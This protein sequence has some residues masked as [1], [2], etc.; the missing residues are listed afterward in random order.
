MFSEQDQLWLAGRYPGLK[1]TADKV[2]GTIDLKAAFQLDT[3]KFQIIYPGDSNVVGGCELTGSFKVTM[4][5]RSSGTMLRVPALTIDGY[6]S[7]KDRHIDHDGIACLCSPFVEGEYMSPDLDGRRFME[8]LVVPFLYGQ[9]SYERHAS[10]P[11]V[12]YSHGF[13]GL[14]E[15]YAPVQS[16]EELLKR[17]PFFMFYRF[18]WQRLQLLISQRRDPRASTP[19]VCGS[20]RRIAHCHKRAL[21]GILALRADKKKFRT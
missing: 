20:R 16:K 4:Q 2:E 12:D 18:D 19:C 11:W 8:E 5:A 17:L 6:P 15:S 1:A 21:N 9:L 3:N 14:V 10:W 7:D 13:A